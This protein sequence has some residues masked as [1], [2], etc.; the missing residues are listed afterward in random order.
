MKV[1]YNLQSELG[2]GFEDLLLLSELY[3]IVHAIVAR[4]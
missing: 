1:S 3:P 2:H 4:V